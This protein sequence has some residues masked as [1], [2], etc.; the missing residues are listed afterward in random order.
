MNVICFFCVGYEENRG[1]VAFF[2]NSRE[3]AWEQRR[4]EDTHTIV[5]RMPVILRKSSGLGLKVLA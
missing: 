3:K 4:V 2:F 1:G 5:R